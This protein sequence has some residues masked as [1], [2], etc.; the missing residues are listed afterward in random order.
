MLDVSIATTCFLFQQARAVHVKEDVTIPEEPL[1]SADD[2]V[3]QVLANRVGDPSCREF[4]STVR[5][6]EPDQQAT[7]WR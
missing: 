7:S 4:I 2:R 3:L 1:N 5:D 6:L